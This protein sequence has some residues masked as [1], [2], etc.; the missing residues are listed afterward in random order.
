MLFQSAKSIGAPVHKGG[1]YICIEGPHFSTRAESQLYRSWGVDVIGMTNVTEAKLAREA[2][3]CYATLAMVTD[4]DCWRCA[5]ADVDIQEIL[6]TLQ[7]NVE[8]AKRIV[9]ELL[10]RDMSS[11][12]PCGCS[13]AL[14]HAVLTD[15][16]SL[17]KQQ[18]D[19]VSLFTGG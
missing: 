14:Q 10:Q 1:T 16:S 5:A 6:A 7:R 15:L 11:N 4:Y 3:C 17:S 13:R 18:R 12:K 8:L 2:Q 19:R 9:M